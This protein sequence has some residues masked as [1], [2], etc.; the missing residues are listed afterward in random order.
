MYVASLVLRT[1][2]LISRA[3]CTFRNSVSTSKC[4]SDPLMLVLPCYTPSPDCPI[5]AMA[6]AL[7]YPLICSLG[8][9]FNLQQE[10]YHIDSSHFAQTV[11]SGF[12]KASRRDSWCAD[13]YTISRAITA[14][15][16]GVNFP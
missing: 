9:I 7:A 5:H 15:D 13:R 1:D 14:G 6:Q 12:Y 8:S 4:A 2:N 11:Y 10:L 3:L 16:S